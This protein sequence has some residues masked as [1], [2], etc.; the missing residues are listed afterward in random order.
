MAIICLD[1][2]QKDL[3][4]RWYSNKISIVEIA[5]LMKVSPR[6]IGRVL[7][8]RGFA[9]PVPRL[10]EEAAGV[11]KLLKKYNVDPR[12]LEGI[13]QRRN[14]YLANLPRESAFK[15]IP[16]LLRP[17]ANDDSISPDAA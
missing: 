1:E 11:M 14:Q 3:I 8:E 6:T 7:V 9:T 2:F 16:A 13:L 15:R 5:D 10:Q 17:S 4:V 12:D